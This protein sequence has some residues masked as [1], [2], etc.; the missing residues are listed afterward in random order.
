MLDIKRN[1]SNSHMT[2]PQGEIYQLYLFKL[3][4]M[5]IN[6]GIRSLHQNFHEFRMPVKGAM[7]MSKAC[8]GN[9]QCILNTK[10]Q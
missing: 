2:W 6:V 10:Q 3:K 8:F 7:N 1:F 9:F 5:V 4:C